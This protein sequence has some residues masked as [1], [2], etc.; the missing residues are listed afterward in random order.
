MVGEKWQHGLHDPRIGASRRVVIQVYR[1][2]Q[3]DVGIPL[4]SCGRGLRNRPGDHAQRGE[5]SGS[6]RRGEDI[7]EGHPAENSGDPPLNFEHRCLN[8]TNVLDFTLGLGSM[9][10]AERQ[11]EAVFDRFEQFRQGDRRTGPLEDVSPL[12]TAGAGHETFVAKFFCS[13]IS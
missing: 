1:Q 13:K 6:R 2:L 4:G 12:D 10:V 5:D 3:H 11:L 9:L 8:R 7:G